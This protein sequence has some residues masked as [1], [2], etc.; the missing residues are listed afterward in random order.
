MARKVKTWRLARYYRYNTVSF[1]I[2]D[3]TRR[4]RDCLGHQIGRP[5]NCL[6]YLLTYLFTTMLLLQQYW[7]LTGHVLAVAESLSFQTAVNIIWWCVVFRRF[8]RHLQISRLTYLLTC[9]LLQRHITTIRH[10]PSAVGMTVSAGWVRPARTAALPV[11]TFNR[12]EL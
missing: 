1:G 9:G 6:T 10:W 8:W 12:L 5:I 3:M 7:S 11:Q 2:R 4:F